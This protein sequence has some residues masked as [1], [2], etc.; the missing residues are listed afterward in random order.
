MDPWKSLYPVNQKTAGRISKDGQ[1][2]KYYDA[3]KLLAYLQTVAPGKDGRTVINN[4][5][6]TQFLKPLSGIKQIR[7]FTPGG[8]QAQVG[9]GGG[10]QYIADDYGEYRDASGQLFRGIKG[11]DGDNRTFIQYA[12]SSNDGFRNPTG[13]GKDRVQPIYELMPDGTARP[14]DASEQYTAGEWVDWGRD[15]AK[16]VATVVGGGFGGA[17]LMG[18][19]PAGAAAGGAAGGLDA[20][21]AAAIAGQSA[22]GAGLLA[23]ESVGG[24]G[25]LEGAGAAAGFASPGNAATIESSLGTPGYGASSAG[26]GGGAAGIPSSSSLWDMIPEAAKSGGSSLLDWVKSNPSTALKLLGTVGGGLLGAAGSGGS[27][28]SSYTPK[29]LPGTFNPSATP[30]YQ[31]VQ[32]QTGLLPAP[33]GVQSSGLWQFT[34]GGNPVTTSSA[35]PY[36]NPSDPRQSTQ[37]VAPSLWSY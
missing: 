2:G 26:P 27:G 5:Q 11:A 22:P 13:S 25:A 29:T 18:A 10:D 37:P 9:E 34:N 8:L 32:Q 30:Q 33:Q 19:A 31:P 14:H 24:L 21:A 35:N 23:A 20:A 17:A 28:G 16:I 12:D 4:G 15:L 1:A 3:D 7:G 36:A 6:F